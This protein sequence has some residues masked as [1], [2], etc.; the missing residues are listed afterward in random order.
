MPR[1]MASHCDW[2]VGRCARLRKI[3]LEVPPRKK[4]AGIGFATPARDDERLAAC[5]TRNGGCK[6]Y[7]DAIT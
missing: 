3:P 2:S 5:K 1:K 6:R 4:A 7:R